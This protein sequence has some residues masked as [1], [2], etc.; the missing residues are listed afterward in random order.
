MDNNVGG[1][2]VPSLGSV[3]ISSG[4][5]SGWGNS[6]SH[7]ND[8]FKVKIETIEAF[9][10]DK[11]EYT[12]KGVEGVKKP[13]GLKPVAFNKVVAQVAVDPIKN[14]VK[15]FTG[16]IK[17]KGWQGGLGII[18]TFAS[19]VLAEVVTSAITGKA[20]DW[21]AIVAKNGGK[22]VSGTV[23]F[24]LSAFSIKKVEGKLTWGE[25]GID[26]IAI[27]KVYN[28]GSF[29]KASWNVL[30]NQTSEYK[31]LMDMGIDPAKNLTP[32]K[33]IKLLK[34]KEAFTAFK[35]ARTT[36]YNS[37]LKDMFGQGTM[38]AIKTLGAQMAC[39]VVFDYAFSLLGNIA[40]G[41]IEGKSLEEIFDISNMHYGSEALKSVN[42]TIF[43]FAGRF[44]GYSCGCPKLGEIAGA[45][46]GSIVNN[47]ICAP[48]TDEFG[49]VDEGWCAIAAGAEL[50]GAIAGGVIAALC[51][52]TG[53][54]G[55]IIGLG[56]LIGAAIAY[57][58][59]ALIANWDKVWE[60]F[61]NKWND[62]MNIGA[63]AV[64]AVVN[65]A[66]ALWEGFTN[67]ASG[68]IEVVGNFFCDVGE[69]IS[70]G[71]EGLMDIGATAI[72]ALVNGAVS[73][74]E[75]ATEFFTGAVETV[76]DFFCET[77]E[78][79]GE[80]FTDAG[81]WIATAWDDATSWIAYIF[82]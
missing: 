8:A 73:L 13:T 54:V 16:L 64:D 12:G 82:A 74:W 10:F 53:P 9:N 2:V 15:D 7:N 63:A 69:L 80:F 48:F 65:G 24:A 56:I 31:I 28:E 40:S 23:N 33:T 17:S 39:V 67:F 46:I 81:D 36:L 35:D 50:A 29:I 71:W 42:K 59:T 27:G 58:I 19:G 22:A 30:K 52:G 68:A 49:N 38:Q 41:I 21:D 72:D 75:G 4:Y 51:I 26:K 77:G 11:Y 43:M 34:N 32:L 70:D 45:L 66:V 37:L 5:S 1:A 55:W 47:W 79:I 25:K 44:I 76:G 6:Y 62:L 20:L 60:F 18:T 61:T 14:C 78:M 3:S 57:G